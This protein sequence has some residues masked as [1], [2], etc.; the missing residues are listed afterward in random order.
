MISD[1]E[2]IVANQAPSQQGLTSQLLEGERLKAVQKMKKKSKRSSRSND[3]TKGVDESESSVRKE[4]KK[5][6]KK[7]KRLARKM[8]NMSSLL[9]GTNCDEDNI[10]SATNFEFEESRWNVEREVVSTNSQQGIKI[11]D[12]LSKG[13]NRDDLE[14]GPSDFSSLLKVYTDSKA[15]ADLNAPELQDPVPNAWSS[16]SVAVS[17]ESG[18]KN[19]LSPETNKQSIMDDLVSFAGASLGTSMEGV[20]DMLS[21]SGSVGTNDAAEAVSHELLVGHMV[22]MGASRQKAESLAFAFTSQQSM[23]TRHARAMSSRDFKVRK[24]PPASLPNRGIISVPTSKLN[25]SMRSM[26]REDISIASAA[27]YRRHRNYVRAD[28]PGAVEMEGR[29]FGAPIRFPS[30]HSVLSEDAVV[31]AAVPEYVVEAQPVEQEDERELVFADTS[32]LPVKVLCTK[33]PVRRVVVS[34]V[35][36]LAAAIA[37]M[38]YFLI[39]ASRPSPVSEEQ[40][41]TSPS[42]SPTLITDS[43]LDAAISLSGEEVVRAPNSPQFRAVGWLS[44]E[45]RVD[46]EDYDSSFVQRYVLVTFFYATNGENWLE[47]DNWLNPLLHEC[48]WGSG[49]SCSTDIAN[50]LLVDGIDLTRNGLTGYIPDE[51]GLLDHLVFLKLSKNALSGTLPSSL[52]RLSRLVNMDLSSNQI[53]GMLP[54]DFGN[55]TAL[56]T[57]SLSYNLITGGLP[58]SLWN[59]HSLRIL[60][61]RSNQLV[62]TISKSI[63]RLA[64]L[65]SL[66]LGMNSFSGLF[67]R[68]ISALAKLDFFLLE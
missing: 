23:N 42:L 18:S 62:G 45:D 68:N 37:I 50:R 6:K 31:D 38:C 35:L 48:E 28:A 26:V 51:V 39:S 61:L 36:L 55:A 20:S 46:H 15:Q 32:P 53:N 11:I 21:L 7:K 49:I 33:G 60:D 24:T 17:M 44:T 16:S 67:P 27:S 64:K 59:L 41:T 8:E 34:S 10:E 13:K 3:L 4:K 2:D 25:R 63:N 54:L 58:S 43:V 12:D 66:D 65:V 5:E 30:R 22:S 29:A 52:G 40:T 19:C 9:K 56:D 57:L 47:N 14:W 1:G